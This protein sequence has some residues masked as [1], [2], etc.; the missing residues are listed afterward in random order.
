MIAKELIDQWWNEWH[1]TGR[2]EPILNYIAEKAAAYGAE[3]AE[4]AMLADV[5]KMFPDKSK[6]ILKEIL[7]DRI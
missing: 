5:K 6:D 3:Q 7:A 2:K 1:T 4:D